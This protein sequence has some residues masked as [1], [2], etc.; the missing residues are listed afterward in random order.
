MSINLALFN[1]DLLHE[2]SI[3]EQFLELV[4]KEQ[5][6][7]ASNDID[8]LED[9]LQVK[10]DL[11]SALLIVNNNRLSSLAKFGFPDKNSS[12]ALLIKQC[13]NVTLEQYWQQLINIGTQADEVNK[14]NGYIVNGLFSTNQNTLA[15]LQG[16]N[17]NVLYGPDG[18][19]T[20]H[21]TLR[22]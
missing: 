14:N 7:L 8:A 1:Q 5:S 22:T 15:F 13:N 17:M 3:M 6:I 4:I 19:N 11:M 2:I 20:A 18:H 12:M 9:L 16:K 21:S 10:S